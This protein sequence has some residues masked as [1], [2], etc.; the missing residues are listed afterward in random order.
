MKTIAHA[1]FKPISNKIPDIKTAIIFF[2]EK[3]EWKIK[4]A[5]LSAGIK[6]S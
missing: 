4:K 1:E 2:N 5:L 6:C 3:D